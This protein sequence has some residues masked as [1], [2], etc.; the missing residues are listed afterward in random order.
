MLEREMIEKAIEFGAEQATLLKR[1]VYP[2]RARPAMEACG[3][4]VY[5]TVRDAGF[6]IHVLTNKQC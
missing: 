1:C 2:T 4:D 5:N 3:I 6:D